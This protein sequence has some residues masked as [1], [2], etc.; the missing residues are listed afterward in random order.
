[1]LKWCPSVVVN[2]FNSTLVPTTPLSMKPTAPVWANAVLNRCLIIY[3]V[4]AA[5]APSL[6]PKSEEPVF[7]SHCCR[8]ESHLMPIDAGDQRVSGHKMAHKH[9]N[10]QGRC[11]WVSCC[12]LEWRYLL[13]VCVCVLPMLYDFLWGWK[14]GL[15]NTIHSILG[16]NDGLMLERVSW[17]LM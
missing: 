1:M 13:S 14:T 15:H 12:T 11:V 6:S 7:V 4:S 9:R 16:W 2:R 8:G 10:N 3:S 17:K 5:A